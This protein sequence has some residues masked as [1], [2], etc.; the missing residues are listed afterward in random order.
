MATSRSTPSRRTPPGR[1]TGSRPRPRADAG[2]SSPLASV[3]TRYHT[4]IFIGLILLSLLIFFGSVI[5]GGKFFAT[6]DNISWLSFVPYLDAM[7][8]KG[9]HPFWIPYIFSGMPAYGAYLVTGDR[10]WD[11]SM[12][13]LGGA[14]KTFAFGNFWLMRVI[15][16]YFIFGIGMYLLM[17]SK[18]AARSTSFFVSLAA[19]FS[20]WII[21]YIMIGHNTKIAVLMTF[22]YIFLCLEKLLQRWSFLYAGLLIL[23]VHIMVEAAHPQTAFYGGAAIGIY[24]LFELIGGAMDRSR[25]MMMGVLRAGALLV[26][27]G[28]LSY[29]MGLDRY[30]A[31]QE[32]TP[33]STRGAAALQQDSTRVGA[34]GDDGH[35]YQYATDWSFSPEEMITYV[36]PS[37]FGFGKVDYELP[38][39]STQQIM[40]YW[41][42]MPFT[43]AAH[44]MGIAVL[45][46]GLFGA[47]MNRKNRFVQALMVVGA[48]GLLLSFGK[49]FPVLYNLFYDYFPSFSK[50][51]A[52]SQSLVL[53]EFIFP[54]L[55]GF[56]IESLIAMHKS[57][58][59]PR[60]DKSILTMTYA[61]GGF[62]LLGL[63]AVNVAR[64]SY[65]SAVVESF[66]AKGQRD[67][68]QLQDFIF[69]NMQTDW[70]FALF[71]GVGTLLLM[72]FYARGRV[73]PLTFKLALFAILIFDLWRVDYRPMGDAVP[74][75]EAFAV[76]QPTDIDAFLQSDTTQFRIL[77]L[78]AA[79]PNFP[80]RQFHQHI[81]GYHAAKMRSYQDLLDIA[82]NGSVPTSPTAWSILNT[83]YIIAQQPIAE[84]LTPVFQSRQKQ[85][86]VFL[87][88][89]AMPRA[90]FVNRVEVADPRTT[91]TRIRDN[92]F[93]PHEVAYVTEPLSATI[94]PV[95]YVPA[96]RR[97]DSAA[98][99]DSAVTS[100]DMNSLA[101][102]NP[103]RGRVSITGWEPHSIRMD[104][105][106]PGNNF[107]VI[108]EIHYPPGWRAT[109]DGKP[110][111]IIR[112]NYVLR[113]LVVPAGKHT[114]EMHYVAEGFDAARYTS[115]AL[116]LVMFACIGY[117]AYRERRRPEDADPEHDAAVIEEDDV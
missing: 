69:S 63:I 61:F 90:W 98:P 85:A 79:G 37:Y 55:A 19:M 51:R 101:Q 11:L 76:F 48:F 2:K 58:D 38:S 40:T 12:S 34:D 111:D 36:V 83:K 100:I 6:N 117:G 68:A 15:L 47:W 64:S 10:W 7:D 45:I 81:L 110:A 113:G 103:G 4:P 50:L 35:G 108:S 70:L 116:N 73:S 33:Y 96:I 27:A 20:T 91:L 29:G 92:A 57:G 44:Y 49:N 53:L 32:Y 46:L 52:P 26:L 93:D 115:L 107:L 88:E 1:G 8:A 89:T 80:A 102:P 56:G 112:T 109:I 16:H 67:L 25:S 114:I 66:Q 3:P 82:G 62:C 5:F 65:M 13:I 71:F 31:I 97:A 95:G 74:K 59:D 105:E 30:Q 78:T 86:M 21:I 14:E 77:D 54:I 72:Y 87:N 43:D 18:K 23:A 99:A 24:L 75:E 39:G 94:E 22:P 60:A 9:Q 104:V 42:Q 17:R 41:G 84:G 28:A 106:A